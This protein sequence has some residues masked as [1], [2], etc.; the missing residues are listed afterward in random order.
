MQTDSKTSVFMDTFILLRICGPYFRK[1]GPEIHRGT[2]K[3]MRTYVFKL[4]RAKKNKHINRKINLAGS[5]YN[6]LIALHRRCYRLFGRGI[7]VTRIQLHIT[8]LKKTK[9]YSFW[10]NLGSQAI[11]DIAQRIDRAY[12]LFFNNLKRGV[13]T[14]PPGF[15]KVRRYRSFTLKQAGYKLCGGNEIVVMGRKYKFFKSREIAGNIKILTIKRDALGDLWLYF[16]TDEELQPIGARSGESVGLDFG[17]KTFLTMSDGEKIESPLYMRQA[18]GRLKKLSRKLSSK[19][20][21]S[22]NRA[23]TRLNL[24]RVHSRIASQ[25]RDFHYKLALELARRYA[26]IFVEDLNMKAMQRLWG[27]K[28]S[29]L[30]HAQFLNILS[31]EMYK[32]GCQG[33]KIDRFYP[34]SKTCSACLHVLPELPL[35]VRTWTCPQCGQEHDRDVNAALNIQRVGASTLKGEDVRP[36]LSGCLC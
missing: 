23:K 12:K 35:S 20:R 26:S 13:R 27:R 5:I 25:R 36:E 18:S 9:R 4:Y 30:G 29:D 33:S 1:D 14:S 32:N 10:N 17:L 16:V 7:S 19:K 15:K 11:Q 22:K 21:G 8:K 31:W 24:A 34:S 28:I 6:H 3:Q 2:K